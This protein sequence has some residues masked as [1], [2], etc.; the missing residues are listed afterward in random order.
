MCG[1]GGCLHRRRA[2]RLGR[3][4]GTASGDSAAGGADAKSDKIEK[5]ERDIKRERL[6]LPSSAAWDVTSYMR[7]D[8]RLSVLKRDVTFSKSM[9]L[10]CLK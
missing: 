8:R 9:S 2:C 7:T 3:R 10:R 1:P 5:S 4:S 6:G